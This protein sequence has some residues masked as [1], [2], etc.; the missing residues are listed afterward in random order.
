M[1]NVGKKTSFRRDC[2]TEVFFTNFT[3]Y[4]VGKKT[5]FRR[6]CDYG[7]VNSSNLK[8]RCRKKDLI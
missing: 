7:L 2:D 8:K 6:D 5:S 1:G 4:H 3:T